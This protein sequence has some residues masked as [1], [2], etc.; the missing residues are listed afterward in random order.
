M[1][2]QAEKKKSTATVEKVEKGLKIGSIALTTLL[3]LLQIYFVIKDDNEP[4]GM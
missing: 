4:V 2:P 1:P 3:G